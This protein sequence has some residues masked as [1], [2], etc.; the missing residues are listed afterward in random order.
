LAGGELQVRFKKL[1]RHLLIGAPTTDQQ[2]ALA[3]HQLAPPLPGMPSPT[4]ITAGYVLN[5]TETALARIVAVCH[6]GADVHYSIDLQPSHA[7]AAATPTLI[8]APPS[9][10]AHFVVRSARSGNTATGREAG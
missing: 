4:V 2:L 7:H 1:D 9:A 5:D 8:A 10:L 6:Y 3:Y